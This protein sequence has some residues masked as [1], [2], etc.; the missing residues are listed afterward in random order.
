M[1]VFQAE[2]QLNGFYVYLKAI[3]LGSYLLPLSGYRTSSNSGISN[4]IMNGSKRRT[5]MK[6]LVLIRKHPP[7][8]PGLADIIGNSPVFNG[9][10]EA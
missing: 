4:Y 9:Q 3:I 6:G 10:E 5:K 8:T 1:L 7:H 2:R